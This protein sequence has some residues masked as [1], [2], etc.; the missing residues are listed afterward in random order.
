[1]VD[2][3]KAGLIGKIHPNISAKENIY[4]LEIDFWIGEA[5]SDVY[6]NKMMRGQ[7][8]IGFGSIS[9]SSQMGPAI[10]EGLKVLSSTQSISENLT[11]SWNLP[12]NDPFSDLLIY[13]NQRWSYDALIMALCSNITV[14]DGVYIE[15][16]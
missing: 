11:L 7:Y 13:N 16:Q 15:N 3:K 9:L 14:V 10:I 6:Y 1:M 8:D 4:V 12:T 2:G 5:W